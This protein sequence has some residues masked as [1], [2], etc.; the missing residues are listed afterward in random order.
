VNRSDHRTTRFAQDCATIVRLLQRQR[1]GKLNADDERSLAAA[2]LAV[3]ESLPRLMKVDLSRLG[4]ERRDV[5]QEALHRFLKAVNAG[6]VQEGGEP[7]GYLLVTAINVAR[8]MARKPSLPVP[9]LD[10]VDTSV[11]DVDQYAELLDRLAS[12]DNVR[13]ALRTAAGSNDYTM[14]AVV[15]AWLDIA[16]ELGTAPSSRQVATELAMSK[17][18]VNNALDRLRSYLP[19][20]S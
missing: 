12:A 19:R 8:S 5:A 13:A 1:H 11:A 16:H 15:R 20:P 3:T 4:I 10:A 9:N 14:I 18:S 7:A 2:L 6:K 17:T